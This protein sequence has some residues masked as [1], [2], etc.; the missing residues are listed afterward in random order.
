MNKP[1]SISR[2]L[3]PIW[4]RHFGIQA[5]EPTKPMAKPRNAGE[6][7]IQAV[8]KLAAAHPKTR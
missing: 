3:T 5:I 1:P 2:N 7:L 6:A 8:Q 4:Q